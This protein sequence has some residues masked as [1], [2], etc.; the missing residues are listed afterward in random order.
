MTGVT[1]IKNDTGETT[2]V[3]LNVATENEAVQRILEDLIDIQ[4]L[5]QLAQKRDRTGDVS[6]E[7][8][9]KEILEAGVPNSNLMD[10]PDV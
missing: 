8:V 10:I 1:Y 9:R 3:V 6:L 4:K 7:D 5:E 2:H